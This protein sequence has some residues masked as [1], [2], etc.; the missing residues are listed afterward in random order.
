MKFL[1]FSILVLLFLPG[2]VSTTVSDT[3][4]KDKTEVS[5]DVNIPITTTVGTSIPQVQQKQLVTDS[6]IIYVGMPKEDLEKFRFTKNTRVDY[7]GEGNEEWITFINWMT[8]KPDDV[9]TFHLKEDKVVD[10]EENESLDEIDRV[11]RTK[12][13]S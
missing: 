2:C 1:F 11:Q 12:N 5:A 13:P 7:Y 6:G 10:W 3:L 9:M 8:E 4:V